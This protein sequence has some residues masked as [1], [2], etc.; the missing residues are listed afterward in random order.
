MLT[1]SEY[2]SYDAL[3]LKELV[4]KSEVTPKELH[5]TASR[6]IEALNPELNFMVEYSPDAAS[7]S[8]ASL[9]PKAPFAGIP[10]LV[11]DGSGLA[12]LSLASGS[13]LGV[14]TIC[15]ADPEHTKRLKRSGL[16]ILGSTNTPEI[17][18]NFSTESLLNGAAR[19]PWNMEH[20]TGGSSGGASSAVA[21]GVVPMAQSSDGAGSIRVPAHFCGVFGLMPT[22]GRTPLAN[23]F[24]LGGGLI[25]RQHVT[26]RTVRDSAAMLDQLH[27]P[28]HGAF[29]NLGCG[30]LLQ[31]R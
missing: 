20:S 9:N 21:A 6:A 4:D 11:K 30:F 24:A 10:F 16:I 3:G 18:S 13:R 8:L 19:N 25:A 26:T 12:G 27:G 17:G 31:R 1:P 15:E 5:D 14:G 7:Q 2:A 22:R 23:S 29:I 28:E